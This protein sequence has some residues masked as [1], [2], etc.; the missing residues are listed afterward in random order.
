M[1]LS[2][3][4]APDRA[5]L[6]LPKREVDRALFSICTVMVRSGARIVYSGNLDPSGLTFTMFRHLAG[7]YVATGKAPF[8]HIIPEPVFRETTFDAL[9]LVLREGASVVETLVHIEGGLVPIRSVEDGLR[10]GRGASSVRLRNDEEF[11]IWLEAKSQLDSASAFSAAR[12]SMT[13][14]SQARVVLG[15]KMGLL[16][17]PDD[18]Y[19]GAMPGIVEETLLALAADLPCVPLGAFGGAARDVAIALHLLDPA[20]RVP[21]GEQSA[22]YDASLRQVAAYRHRIPAHLESALKSLA[23]DDRSEAMAYEIADLLELWLTHQQALNSK[24]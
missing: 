10:V 1:A 14:V 20:K 15:G 3:S 12:E 18:A 17:V 6:G 23:D 24:E 21:R 19:Q 11:R 5:R 4:D 7:A 13:H 2:V 22:T 9:G 16:D 8:I